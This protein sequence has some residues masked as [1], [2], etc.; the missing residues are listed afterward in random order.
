MS[1]IKI[2]ILLH[3][4]HLLKSCQSH[5]S[6]AILNDQP[7]A[8]SQRPTCW[9]LSVTNVVA[10]EPKVAWWVGT[11]GC[12]AVGST[13]GCLQRSC[14]R[15]AEMPQSLPNVI[16]T[17]PWLGISLHIIAILQVKDTQRC[18][19]VTNC[20]KSQTRTQRQ[21]N[22]ESRFTYRT[23]DK[24]GSSKHSCRCESSKVLG[25]RWQHTWCGRSIRSS[26]LRGRF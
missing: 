8:A 16:K 14:W 23:M 19:V 21:T 17:I 6:T 9:R 11:P 7:L 12:V 5:N 3:Q 10:L 22:L 20:K 24:D 13:V 1:C 26:V 15:D 2:Y 18:S 25:H 4:L